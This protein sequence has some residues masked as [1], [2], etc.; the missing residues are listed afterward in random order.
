MDRNMG[1]N[2]LAMFIVDS[3]KAPRL[4]KYLR[5]IKAPGWTAFLGEGTAKSGLLRTLG[6]ADLRKEIIITISNSKTIESICQKV[7]EKFNFDKPNAGIAFTI[8]LENVFGIRNYNLDTEKEE[9]EMTHKAI[10]TIVDNGKSRK[11]L[12]AAE[13]AGSTGGTVI[14]ARGSAN[15]NTKML[16]N[17]PIQPE[18][19]IVLNIARTENADS[20][21]ETI[22]RELD[23]DSPGA[24]IIF[25][26]DTQETFGLL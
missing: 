10:F 22:R 7:S 11:V 13:S 15:E 19:E 17:I 3:N 5:E 21:V 1:D 8:A 16:F 2:H 14:H 18:K 24:G 20:I 25:T 12:Q 23:I 26:V 9:V 6:L 4:T